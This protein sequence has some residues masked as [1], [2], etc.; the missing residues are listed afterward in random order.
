MAYGSSAGSKFIGDLR[1]SSFINPLNLPHRPASRKNC[2]KGRLSAREFATEAPR[3][4][5]EVVREF[6]KFCSV[7]V[8]V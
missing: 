7:R 6:R 2:L 4:L 5:I 1:S 3:G 8:V